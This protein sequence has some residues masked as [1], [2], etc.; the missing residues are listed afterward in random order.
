[1]KNLQRM[2][3][4]WT[5]TVDKLE[6]YQDDLSL[7]TNEMTNS[8]SGEEQL[9]DAAQAKLVT[10]NDTIEKISLLRQEKEDL[11]TED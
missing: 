1:M 2:T 10:K 6:L 11:Q 7:L 4:E 3:E 9:A 5:V 8:S